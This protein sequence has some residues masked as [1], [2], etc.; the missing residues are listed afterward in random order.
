ML[1]QSLE[2][3]P[4]GR[5]RHCEVHQ[6]HGEL[7]LGTGAELDSGGAGNVAG[8]GTSPCWG[9]RGL[10]SEEGEELLERKC[11]FGM[12]TVGYKRAMIKCLQE[13]RRSVRLPAAGSGRASKRSMRAGHELASCWSFL[14]EEPDFGCAS[15][16]RS[17]SK[18]SI[19]ESHTCSDLRTNTSSPLRA[20]AGLGSAV[21]CHEPGSCPSST[22]SS[23]AAPLHC[24]QHL[25]PLWR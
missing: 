1:K 7:G 17:C 9:L 15:C 24:Q 25:S 13:M 4:E 11:S 22:S 3:C 14:S 19:L 2:H 12:S 21:M 23:S 5:V 6:G 16:P 8:E 18:S 20:K 10:S